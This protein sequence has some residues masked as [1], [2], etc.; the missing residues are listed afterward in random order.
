M[1]KKF[2]NLLKSVYVA[3]VT[4]LSNNYSAGSAGLNS[5][6]N[7]D[8]PNSCNCLKHVKLQCYDFEFLK[9]IYRMWLRW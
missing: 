3:T 1:N 5:S 7:S 6:F 2:V 9:C 8:S 4:M